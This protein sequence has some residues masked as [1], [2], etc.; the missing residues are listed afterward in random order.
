MLEV[1]GAHQDPIRQHRDGV[2]G[3]VN[4]LKHRIYGSQI[5]KIKSFP[6]SALYLNVS[7]ESQ[8]LKGQCHEKSFQTETV[9][10]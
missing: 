4:V 7:M 1:F 6:D 3:Q 8:A 10:V 9:G 5:K 2:E